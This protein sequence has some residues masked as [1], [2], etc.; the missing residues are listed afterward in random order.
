MTCPSGN[1]H[2]ETSAGTR[3]SSPVIAEVAT[4][5][6]ETASTPSTS[7]G[8]VPASRPASAATPRRAASSPAD[9]ATQAS[10]SA[11]PPIAS[12]GRCQ[13]AATVPAAMRLHQRSP[14]TATTGR[15]VL[16]LTMTSASTKA[17]AIVAW[18]LG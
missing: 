17:V 5:R 2:H 14:S 12:L 4:A 11:I 10:A 1:S 3:A 7:H 8:T 16:R 6:A 18:P 9:S 13:P 15:I